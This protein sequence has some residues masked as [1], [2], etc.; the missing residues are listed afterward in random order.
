MIWD[1][2]FLSSLGSVIWTLLLGIEGEGGGRVR[3]WEEERELNLH[4]D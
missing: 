4:F 3:V 1:M 2:V